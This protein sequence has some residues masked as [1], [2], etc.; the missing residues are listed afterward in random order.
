MHKN[1]VFYGNKSEH[2][3]TVLHV[4]FDKWR[5]LDEGKSKEVR[6]YF[7]NK[8]YTL[9]KNFTFKINKE[10]GYK[11]ITLPDGTLRSAGYKAGYEYIH[12]QAWDGKIK[13][14]QRT[15]SELL[16]KV[17]S[18]IVSISDGEL[19]ELRNK[20]QR[21]QERRLSDDN[22]MADFLS[23]APA[24]ANNDPTSDES[25]EDNES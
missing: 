20:V 23:E 19:E 4:Y 5:L 15:H 6:E 8:A 22:V 11:A 17:P 25:E 21:E 14:R 9:A 18:L 13:G 1:N 7:I 3:L 16:Q 12:H 24:N 10:E 2:S